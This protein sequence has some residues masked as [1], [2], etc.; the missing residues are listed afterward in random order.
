MLRRQLREEAVCPLQLEEL[1]ASLFDVLPASLQTLARHS[2]LPDDDSGGGAEQSGEELSFFMDLSAVSRVPGNEAVRLVDLCGRSRQAAIALRQLAEHASRFAKVEKDVS[3]AIKTW[4]GEETGVFSDGESQEASDHS[5][6]LSTSD[7]SS[8]TGVSSTGGG[9]ASKH[10]VH[11]S[12]GRLAGD[13]AGLSELRERSHELWA[14]TLLLP[15]LVALS[16]LVTMLLRRVNAA[17]KNHSQCSSA[18]VAAFSAALLSGFAQTLDQCAS[19]CPSPS[20]L[21][22]VDHLVD[23]A[24]AFAETALMSMALKP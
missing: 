2:F 12:V 19:A 11:S 13:G 7:L 6:Q 14:V 24:I 20:S 21:D 3:V 1:L 5:S 18:S 15:Q 8:M 9:F 22:L 17:L 23:A 10:L 16:D 4:A